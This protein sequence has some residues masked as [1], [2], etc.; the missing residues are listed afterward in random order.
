MKPWRV[1]NNLTITWA[2]DPPFDAECV[3]AKTAFQATFAVQTTV[4]HIWDSSEGCWEFSAYYTPEEG[5][6]E[7]VGTTKYKPRAH[8][9][10]S[11]TQ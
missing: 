5:S 11:V 7:C 8:T 10:R 1:S 2:G 6:S 3:A 4:L 9:A